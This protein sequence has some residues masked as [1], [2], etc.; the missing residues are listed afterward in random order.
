MPAIIDY[1]RWSAQPRDARCA[2]PN[3]PRHRRP[4]C[5]PRHPRPDA[6]SSPLR[7]RLVP[8]D[9]GALDRRAHPRRDASS[10]ARRR[11]PAFG[12]RRP[13]RSSPRSRVPHRSSRRRRRTGARSRSRNRSLHGHRRR[14]R[15]AAAL[16]DRAWRELLEQHHALVRQRA[17]ALPRRRGRHRGDGFLATFDGPARAISLRER[18]RRGGARARHRDPRRA[19]HR[20]MRA[21]GRQGRGHRRP[22]RRPRGVAAPA[23]AKSS[24]R[25]R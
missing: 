7:D 8:V 2:D 16:G 12:R 1:F 13:T 4:P 23:R 6:A 17:R 20:R 5:P 19:A 24:C 3:E 15:K 10:S 21:H 25:A 22:H 18:D 14:H 11:P 9:G